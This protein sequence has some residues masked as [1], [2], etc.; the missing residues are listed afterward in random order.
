MAMG[1]NRVSTANFAGRIGG[2]QEFIAD[3]ADEDTHSLLRKQPDAVSL[4]DV[5]IVVPALT[6]ETRLRS[7]LSQLRST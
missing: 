4:S 7:D 2:N 6:L 1:A 5:S 3:P